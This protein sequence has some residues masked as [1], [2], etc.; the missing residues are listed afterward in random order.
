VEDGD[1]RDVSTIKTNVQEHATIFANSFEV[2]PLKV[3]HDKL[4]HEL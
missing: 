3:F 1:P 2:T 4:P